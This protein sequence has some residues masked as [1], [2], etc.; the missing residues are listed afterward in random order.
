[1]DVL[2]YFNET[3]E[4]ALMRFTLNEVEREDFLNSLT[5]EFCI[6]YISK[7]ELE[8]Q[9]KA[10]EMS[11]S[12]F[13]NQFIIP[14]IPEYANVRS[15]DFG[16]MLC[17]ILLRNKGHN[18][19]VWLVG[20]R[21]W[22]WKSDKNKACHGSDVVMFHRKDHKPSSDDGIEVIESKMKSVA[23][24]TSPIQNAINGAVEDK[25][26]RLAK[27]LNWVHDKLATEK[28]P[29]LREA[30]NRYRFLDEYPTYSK[31]FH[32]VALI[33]NKLVEDEMIK[34]VVKDEDIE[35]SIVSMQDLKSAYEQTFSAILNYLQ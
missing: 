22:R 1:M 5:E 28:K 6:N 16:E 31:K 7:S 4:R 35:V 33:D 25:V 29:R 2:K 18:K 20:P 3:V 10:N 21:K 24:K 8:N 19:G 32:A 26:K 9:A 12:D 34:E 17:F 11:K 23:S 30:I 15:G 27:T 14:E 13:F